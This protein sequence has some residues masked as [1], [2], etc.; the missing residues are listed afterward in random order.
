MVSTTGT[1]RA[2]LLLCLAAAASVLALVALIPAGKPAGAATDQLP[3]F[4]MARIINLQIKKCTDTRKDCAYVGQR[5]LRFTTIIVNVGAGAFEVEG[6]N[7]DPTGVLRTVTQH[8]FDDQ[9]GFRS[10]DTKVGNDGSTAQMYYAGDGHD[11]WHLRDLEHYRLSSAPVRTGAK[12][13]FCFFDRS[14][15]FEQDASGNP[16]TP[17][18][19]PR[20]V[21][22]ACAF[23]QPKA[24]SVTVGL[25]R[26]WADKYGAKTFG[27]YIDITD[28]PDGSYR[29][30]ATA[31][32]HDWFYESD[33]TN[34]ST[35]ADLNIQGTQV[36]V[37]SY[38]G[39]DPPLV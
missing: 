27:Q 11:H 33:E 2:L 8:I 13:G 10:V 14:K 15:W 3:D 7:R 24:T 23:N 18:V 4:S 30:R 38:G 32:K 1:K 37:T 29:L 35:R 5:Q 22:N 36:S 25:S 26:G 20:R 28:L 9:G 19:P 12:E 16:I 6:S 21:Y 31:D 17:G 34:N 39:S